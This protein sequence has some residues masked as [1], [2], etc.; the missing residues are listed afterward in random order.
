MHTHHDNISI[1]NTVFDTL[2]M[3]IITYAKLPSNAI[4]NTIYARGATLYVAPLLQARHG[5]I[6][7][8]YVWG[9]IDKEYSR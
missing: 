9:L 7:I 6:G 3:Y 8:F 5:N 4:Y 1:L 2:K